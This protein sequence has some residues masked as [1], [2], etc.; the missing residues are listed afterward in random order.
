[1]GVFYIRSPGFL[2]VPQ[3]QCTSRIP[4]SKR[5]TF[6]TGMH[7]GHRMIPEHLCSYV[8][9]TFNKGRS[10][11]S[12]GNKL[13]LKLGTNCTLHRKHV[14]TIC[15]KLEPQEVFSAQS[16]ITTHFS[17][18]LLDT[19]CFFIGGP[20]LDN[21]DGSSHSL[22]TSRLHTKHAATRS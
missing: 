7:V 11:V 6:H 10:I 19:A 5:G 22:V 21:D 1:M 2:Y 4:V 16:F 17:I 3:L 12:H 14:V 15:V 13:L 9:C 18:V 20:T 8:G